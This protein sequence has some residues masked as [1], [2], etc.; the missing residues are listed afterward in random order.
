MKQNHHSSQL[1]FNDML[2]NILIGFV[3]LFILA[4]LMINPI[5]KKN[6]IPVRAEIMITLEWEDESKDD[7]DLW[8]LGPGMK[9]G[10]LA[11]Y[12]KQAGYLH[13]D[14]DDL[15]IK[16]DTALVD[17][18]EIPLLYNKEIATMRG[19]LPGDYYINVHVYAKRDNTPLKIKVTVMDVNPFQE[20]YVLQ[21]TVT[22]T[23]QIIKFPAFTID[24]SGKI[25]KLFNSEKVFVKSVSES[26]NGANAR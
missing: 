16:N 26:T 19:V 22:A 25:I 1:A 23:G 17:G 21:E 9:A 5:T 14:R 3:V 6:E 11:F 2:F 18:Q 10:P 24:S 15:G 7:I 20:L 12:R 4:F 13:L 8:V